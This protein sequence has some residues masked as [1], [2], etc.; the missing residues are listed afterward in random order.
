MELVSETFSNRVEC[1]FCGEDFT[2]R[3][4]KGGLLFQSKAVCPL[5]ARRVEKDAKKYGE[6][7]L[8]RDRCPENMAFRDWVVV[9]LRSLQ[10]GAT[11]VYSGD[12]FMNSPKDSK[13]G[14]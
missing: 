9:V 2:N 12:D 5:C 10:P 1:D 11:R 6:E 7:Y 14:E 8:I 13:H 3:D 4:D